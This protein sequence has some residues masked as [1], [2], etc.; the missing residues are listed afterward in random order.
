MQSLL[1][2][3]NSPIFLPDHFFYQINTNGFMGK[4]CRIN[5]IQKNLRIQKVEKPH[6]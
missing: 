1:K 5:R 3:M 6:T 2:P 4:R